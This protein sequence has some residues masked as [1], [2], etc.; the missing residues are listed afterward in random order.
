MVDDADPQMRQVL[1]PALERIGASDQ[2]VELISLHSNAI[3]AVREAGLVIRIA[4]NPAAFEAVAASVRVARWLSERGIPA[5]PPGDVPG[6][7]VTIGGRVVSFWRLLPVVESPRPTV[8]DLAHLLRDLHGQVLADGVVPVLRD[9]LSSV[10]AA[11]D[12]ASEAISGSDLRWLGGR[13]AELRRWW[14]K[15]R[16]AG[17]PALIHGDAHDNNL[18]RLADGQVVLGD[19]DHVA[20]G[21][22]EWD[23]VQPHYTHRRFGR[24]D[25]AMLEAFGQAYG[26]DVRSWP[27]LETLIAVRELSGLAPYLR[28]AASRPYAAA[29]LGHRLDTLREGDTH[30]RWQP[31]RRR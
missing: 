7:P 23:L 9:P 13:I 10:A 24:P 11:V 3:F 14:S 18:L 19:W 28:A 2:G 20:V 22:I 21:P 26:R 15:V 6:Q 1:V 12:A 25:S 29:E 5:T 4:T 27:G 30:A 17:E 31:P 16:F 8:V